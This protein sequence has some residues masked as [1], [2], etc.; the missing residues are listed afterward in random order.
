MATPFQLGSGDWT[1]YRSRFNLIKSDE[2]DLHFSRRDGSAL[3]YAEAM[4][5]LTSVVE[6]NL[7]E[8][9]RMGRAH[10]MFTH[11]WSTSRLGK[12][13]AR[14]QVRSFMRSKAATPLIERSQ[15]IQHESV[16]VA[17]LRP[18]DVE[19]AADVQKPLG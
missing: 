9:R 7:R 2:I 3:S 15:C 10:V 11:G 1:Q 18:I 19:D 6:N 12:T 14:S 5:E 8:A 16:F 4:E 13:T 17:K